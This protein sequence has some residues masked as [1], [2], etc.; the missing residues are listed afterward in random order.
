VGSAD[1]PFLIGNFLLFAAGPSVADTQ[2][3]LRQSAQKVRSVFNVAAIASNFA[4]MNTYDCALFDARGVCVS[5]GGRYTS[6]N[7]PDTA[8]SNAV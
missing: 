6:A 5:V 7:S 1:T 3:S 8:T 4:N 2:L